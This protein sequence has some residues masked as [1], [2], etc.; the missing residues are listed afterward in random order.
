[1]K[2]KYIQIIDSL[3]PIDS[4][5]PSVNKIGKKILMRAIEKYIKNIDWRNLSDQL[6][7]IYAEECEK[8][9]SKINF[10]NMNE[11]RF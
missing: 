2:E 7:E 1:M 10:I 4:E 3:F 11:R 5:F 8:E 9:E 6:L